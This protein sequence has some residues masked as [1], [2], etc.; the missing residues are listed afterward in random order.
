MIKPELVEYGGN[1][2]LTK[3]YE[4]I[5]EDTGGKIPLLSNKTTEDIIKYDYGTSYS[6]A[7][8]AYLAGKIARMYP[9]KSANFIKNMLL[10]GS[11]YPFIPDKDFYNT[12]DRKKAE[13]KHLSIC[14]FG[15][16]NYEKAINCLQQ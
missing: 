12:D 9:Q 15:L 11:G 6:A 5:A 8:L 7:K 1:L 13:T 16:S 10:V 4:R 3:K 2:I 14:G